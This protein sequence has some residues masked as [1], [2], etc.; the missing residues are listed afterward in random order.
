ME[1]WNFS[2]VM[3]TALGG[4]TLALLAVETVRFLRAGRAGRRA[5]KTMRKVLGWLAIRVVIGLVFTVGATMTA[6]VMQGLDALHRVDTGEIEARLKESLANTREEPIRFGRTLGHD[7]FFVSGAGIDPDDRDP[8]ANLQGRFVEMEPDPG[9]R[10]IYVFGGSSVVLQEYKRTFPAR[11]EGLLRPDYGLFDVFN[12]GAC[13]LD[14][15]SVKRRA[16]QAMR[17]RKP[18]LVIIYAG[19]EDYNN[20][21]RQVI[22]SHFFLIRNSPILFEMLKTYYLGLYL[23]VSN[24]LSKYPSEPAYWA[25]L[26]SWLEPTLNHWLQGLGLIDIPQ[27][28]FDGFNRVILDA[29]KRNYLALIDEAKQ[30][31]VP[32]VLIT[33]VCNLASRPYG[34]KDRALKLYDAGMAEKR[35]RERIELLVQARDAEAFTFEVRAKSD[36]MAWFRGLDDGKNVFTLDLE[37]LLMERRFQFDD[38]DFGDYSHFSNMVHQVVAEAILDFLKRR[39]VCCGLRPNENDGRRNQGRD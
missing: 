6:G 36:L 22:K 25:F 16:I 24:L 10:L 8:P 30:R 26:E 28:A 32:V 2:T 20:P 37:K 19:H 17:R 3:V 39:K 11:L 13:S 14:S 15:F 27:K 33:P 12:F 1:S 35:Y 38:T 5:P 23:P 29:A 31:G 18:D 34:I 9:D 4:F 7:G 21:Y